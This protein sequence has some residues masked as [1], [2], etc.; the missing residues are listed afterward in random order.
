MCAS[1]IQLGNDFPAGDAEM[2][3][4]CVGRYIGELQSRKIATRH[5]H[6]AL[7]HAMYEYMIAWQRQ[8]ILGK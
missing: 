8:V 7:T 5:S 1:M 4:D 3:L 2:R 6:E